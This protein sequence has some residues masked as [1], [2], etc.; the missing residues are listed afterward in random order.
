[1]AIP[2]RTTVRYGFIGC[3]MMGQEHLRNLALIDG[4]HA[5]AIFE[6]DDAMAAAA[7]ALAPGAVRVPSLDALLAHPGLDDGGARL[8]RP[9]PRPA[10]TVHVR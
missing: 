9:A 5:V 8:S 10:G 4:A 1:M 7:L 3:G 6:P 2:P